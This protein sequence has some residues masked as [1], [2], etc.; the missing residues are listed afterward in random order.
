MPRGLA[1]RRRTDQRPALR[2]V[3]YGIGAFCGVLLLGTLG[4][5]AFE[6]LGPLD[7]LYNTLGLM[8]TSGG[9]VR[10][11]TQAGHILAI[12]VLVAGLSATFYT[13]GV[14]AEFI[15][16]GHLGRPRRAP[17]VLVH[18]NEGCAALPL[19]RRVG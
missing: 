8:T 2:H 5:V 3:W 7:S 11:H 18:N 17:S 15:I 4:F 1:P 19:R 10:P 12:L 13:F 14:L 6:R 9:F 16:E